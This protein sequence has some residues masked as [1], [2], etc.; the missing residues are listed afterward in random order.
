MPPAEGPGPQT[1]RENGRP[2]SYA[3]DQLTWRE[4]SRHLAR[5]PR[6][7]F[8]VGALEQHGSHLPLGTNT[9]LSDQLARS[10]S[11]EL[12]ILRAP[13][14]S[15]GVSMPAH[16]PFGGTSGLRRKTFHRA[17]NELL[18]DWEDDGFRE[19]IILTAHRYEPHLDALLMAL[20]TESVTTVVDLYTIDVSDIVEVPPEAEHAGEVETSLLLHLAP[21]RVRTGQVH[22]YVPDHDTLRK[23]VRGRVPTPPPESEGAVGRPSRASAE[24]GRLIFQRFLDGARRAV[25]ESSGP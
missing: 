2:P 19:F 10:L 9:Y 21:E 17:V 1:E 11:E 5:D 7:V 13:P 22:D 4:V 25:D 12:G 3:L 8:P 20:T 6:L 24:K 15:Y 14:L 16:R 18:A 23:Y